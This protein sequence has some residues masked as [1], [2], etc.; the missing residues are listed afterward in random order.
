MYLINKI[1]SHRERVLDSTDL[2]STKMYKIPP[3]TYQKLSTNYL[4]E[5]EKD[6]QVYAIGIDKNDEY[7]IKGDCFEYSE[8]EYKF[9]LSIDVINLTDREIIVQ[10]PLYKILVINKNEIVPKGYWHT[11]DLYLG[12]PSTITVDKTT[13]TKFPDGHCEVLIAY[14]KN[15]NQE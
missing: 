1:T 3:K 15:N 4:C 12:A 8:N 13:F 10:G 11:E 5:L 6:E 9:E 2:Q 14:T 7:L